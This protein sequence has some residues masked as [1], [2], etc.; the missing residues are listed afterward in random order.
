MDLWPTSAVFVSFETRFS[1]ILIIIN[2]RHESC[3]TQ[4][5]SMQYGNVECVHSQYSCILTYYVSTQ[6]LCPTKILVIVIILKYCAYF[7]VKKCNFVFSFFCF[8]TFFIK[9]LGERVNWCEKI[10][11]SLLYL[12][13]VT[14]RPFL[15]CYEPIVLNNL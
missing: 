12:T 3:L 7:T 2:S 14:S 5:D 6:F 4:I 11:F 9:Y 10:S 1:E 15:C 8:Y 13:L